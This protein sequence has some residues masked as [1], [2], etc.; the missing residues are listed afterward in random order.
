MT[1]MVT[2]IYLNRKDDDFMYAE[3]KNTYNTIAFGLEC[4]DSDVIHRK[5]FDFEFKLKPT[6][7]L[8]EKLISILYVMFLDDISVRNSIANIIKVYDK[9]QK[10]EIFVNE[11][12]AAKLIEFNKKFEYTASDPL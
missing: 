5:V 7:K 8:E 1:N 9:D 11:L 12:I 3:I 10:K 4:R 6:E 2:T